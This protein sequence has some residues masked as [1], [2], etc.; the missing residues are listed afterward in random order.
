MAAG[1][2]RALKLRIRNPQAIMLVSEADRIARHAE[3][4]RLIQQQGLGGRVFVA[5]IGQSVDWIIQRG[6]HRRIEQIT[7]EQRDARR[8]GLQKYKENGGVTGAADIANYS[9]QASQ[10]KKQKRQERQQKVLSAVKKIIRSN[11]GRVPGLQD[12]CDALNHLCIRTGQGRFFTPERLSQFRKQCPGK[13]KQARDSYARPRRRIRYIA[14]ASLIELRNRRNRQW[15]MKQL[16]RMLPDDRTWLD[17]CEL[18]RC[19]NDIPVG[20]AGDQEGKPRSR[21]GC[22]G[23]PDTRRGWDAYVLSMRG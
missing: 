18:R 5:S 1:L 12:I 19:R 10:I 20:I 8:E 14:I 4:F 16:L 17:C 6:G 9:K 21:D 11:H 22:R 13:W 2:G 3:I 7:I 15:A 23:P